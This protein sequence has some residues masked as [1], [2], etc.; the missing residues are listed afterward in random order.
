MAKI[1]HIAIIAEDPEKLAQFYA[2]IYGMEITGRSNGDVWVTDGY[3]DV[4][5]IHQKNLKKP[6][7]LFH[8]GFTL[9]PSIGEFVLSHPDIR[10]PEVGTMYSVNEGNYNSFEEGLRRYIKWCQAED[11]ATGRPYTTRY[12]GSFVSDFHRNLI[13]GGIYIYPASKRSPEG[14]LRLMY[15]ANPLAFICEQAGGAA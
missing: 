6:K 12:I 3:M 13:K 5:L 1:R 11:R 8:F 10:T 9:D 2:D 14:K 7:G 4:A 15:E